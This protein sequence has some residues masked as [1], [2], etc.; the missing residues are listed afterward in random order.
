MTNEK[1]LSKETYVKF[2]EFL[3]AVQ[4]NAAFLSNVYSKYILH[5][6]CRTSGRIEAENFGIK[7]AGAKPTT[8]MVKLGIIDATRNRNKTFES[9]L[10][11]QRESFVQPINS[12]GIE[13]LSA[14][15]T[16]HAWGLL[17]SQ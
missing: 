1:K 8:S 7:N 10:R 15:M 16:N 6:G 5:L 9:N 2:C 17:Q 13:D 11:Y 3:K 14:H 12:C 4:S